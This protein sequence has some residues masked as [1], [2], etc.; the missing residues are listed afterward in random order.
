M[1]SLPSEV[2][3]YFIGDVIT[4]ALNDI[5]YS[6]YNGDLELLQNYIRTAQCNSFA[7]NAALDVYAQLCVD[8]T[9]DKEEFKNF[10]K[11]LI[12]NPLDNEYILDTNI[13]GIICLEHFY[14]MLQ[15][16]RYLLNEERI[17][18]YIYGKYEDLFDIM[19]EYRK[20]PFCEIIQNAANTIRHWAM[21]KQPDSK[22]SFSMRDFEKLLSENTRNINQPQKVL[23]I[24]RNDACPCGSGKKYK[25][26]CINKPVE[27][28]FEPTSEQIKWL[29]RYPP[30]KSDIAEDRLYPEDFFDQESIMIDKLLY[31]GRMNRPGFPPE[32]EEQTKERSC[33]Y[34]R[35]AF[36]PFMEKC[37]RENIKSFDEYDAKYMIYFSS[38]DWVNELMYLLKEKRQD[39]DF[40]RVTSFTKRLLCPSSLLSTYISD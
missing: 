39:D 28:S 34:L 20:E 33:Y 4:E 5:L 16:V 22:P 21:F 7:K 14:D 9:A 40:K 36:D 18:E 24:G 35:K 13:A 19:F 11:D 37:E 32:S 2:L 30:A 10:L 17:D 27:K 15:E 25:H 3:D 1:I 38:L 29:K 8:H 12:Y 26:C 31:L 6:T 23:K